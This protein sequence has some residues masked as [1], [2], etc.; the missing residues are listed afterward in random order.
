MDLLVVW[1]APGSQIMLLGS[2]LGSLYIGNGAGEALGGGV[3]AGCTLGE[4]AARGGT[5]GY[6]CAIGSTLGGTRGSVAAE[7]VIGDPS[8]G[9]AVVDAGGMV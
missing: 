9:V 6:G 1:A 7:D 4:G 8:E 5:L 2:I 3:A